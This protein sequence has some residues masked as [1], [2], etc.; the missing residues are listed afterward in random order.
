MGLDLKD[1]QERCEQL[2]L[3]AEQ[4]PAQKQV[5]L[6]FHERLTRLENSLAMTLRALKAPLMGFY[7]GED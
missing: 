2:I 4:S 6:M 3:E 7:P 1:I 5:N